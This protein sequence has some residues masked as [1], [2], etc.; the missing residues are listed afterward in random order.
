VPANCVNGELD[1]NETDLD[2]GGDCPGCNNGDDC[3]NW[4]DCQ[5]A[6]C[7][8]GVCAPCGGH[9]DCPESGFCNPRNSC[10]PKKPNGDGCDEGI[11]CQSGNCPGQDTV[12]CDALCSGACN[13]CRFSKTGLPNG[14]CHPVLVDT[15]PDDECPPICSGGGTAPQVCNGDG[16]CVAG[17]VITSCSIGC[18]DGVCLACGM[19]PPPS[20]PSCPTICSNGCNGG[21]CQ[22]NC[23][24]ANNCTSP[25]NCPPGLPCIVMCIGVGGCQQKTINCPPSHGCSLVCD[26][27]SANLCSNALL[28]CGAGSCDLSCGPNSGACG[29]VVQ[30][31]GPNACTQS[32]DSS[33]GE[34]PVM[35][36]GNACLCTPC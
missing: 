23:S 28:N 24:S 4:T 31:C 20:A 35:T 29:G 2:C 16:S 21:V 36:C 15:D 9:D 3:L 33:S 22:I 5:S 19:N 25:V 7:D 11:E 30:T 8:N 13:A 18:H 32:C 10:V 1:G 27:D 34:G 14:E 6:F 12:C 26:E 17:N